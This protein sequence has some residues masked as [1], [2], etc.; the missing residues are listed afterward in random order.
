VCIDPWTEACIESAIER[1]RP[2]PGLSQ[3]NLRLDNPLGVSY[4][5]H[6]HALAEPG[7]SIAERNRS[8]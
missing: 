5:M 2:M 7:Q 8:A 3:L 6:R 1:C 4:L